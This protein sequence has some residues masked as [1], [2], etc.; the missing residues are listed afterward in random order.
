MSLDKILSVARGE[1]GVKEKPSG[2]NRTKYG[3]WYGVDGQP[4][5]AMYCSWVYD[6]AG[7]P[8]PVI[9]QGAPSGA[10]YCPYI[11]S[12]AKKNSQWYHRPKPGDLALFSFGKRLS[13]HIG[14]VEKVTNG[15]RFVSIEG[16]TSL[17][18]N[19]NGG[20][21]MRRNRNIGQ[22][23]GFYRPKTEPVKYGKDA[24]YRLIEL[25]LPL[26]YGHDIK[27]WQ[28][29]MNYFQYE[30][31]VDGYYGENSEDACKDLQ[32][33]R[34]LEVDGVVGPMTWKETFERD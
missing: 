14:I 5:C 4:W 28:K 2:S 8:L 30:L 25:K 23:R 13:V 26:M 34:N 33:K 20:C 11:E 3:K 27:E 12:Y 17:S 10:A 32:K 1:L 9:Q 15:D 22:C 24:Y 7:C 19:D 6:Q 18:S 16:N 21:V 29:Q 31:E